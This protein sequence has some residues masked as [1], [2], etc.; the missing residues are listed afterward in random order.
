VIVFLILAATARPQAA[1]DV[2][3]RYTTKDGRAQG[4][5]RLGRPD[6]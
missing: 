3:A 6:A 2:N 4:G 1:G 5:C